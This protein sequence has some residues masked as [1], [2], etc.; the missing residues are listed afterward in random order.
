MEKVARNQPGVEKTIQWLDNFVPRKE[1]TA[2]AI[3]LFKEWLSDQSGYDE[4]TLPK[5]MKALDDERRRVGARTL[6]DD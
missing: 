5:L 1:S 2:R 6:F 4:E 3:A